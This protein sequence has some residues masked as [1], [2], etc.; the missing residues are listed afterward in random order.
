M[1]N[2]TD[3]A[4]RHC[5]GRVLE[6]V[7]EGALP[8]HRCAQCGVEQLGPIEN[9]CACGARVGKRFILACER[10]PEPREPGFP[11]VGVRS[12]DADLAPARAMPRFV[13]GD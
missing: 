11:E 4:C 1:W 5:H 2:L 10:M 7:L 12:R 8:A 9:L 13:G 6:R 3:H